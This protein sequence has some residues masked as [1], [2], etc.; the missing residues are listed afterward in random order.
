MKK[1]PTKYIFHVPKQII[2]DDIETSDLHGGLVDTNVNILCRRNTPTDYC[3]FKDDN[4]Q[5]ILLSDKQAPKPTDKY[6][7]RS[8]Y[9]SIYILHFTF[10]CSSSV[11][12]SPRIV[13][14]LFF[15]CFS[16]AG[17]CVYLDTMVRA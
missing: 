12:F 1:N 9:Y 5:K 8:I 2:L 13:T 11:C 7:F 4:G 16:G 14:V 6:K 15:V 3:W 10:Y 17:V